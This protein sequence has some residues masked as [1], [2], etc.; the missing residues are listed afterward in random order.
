MT[1]EAELQAKIA[2]ISGKIN[3]AKQQQPHHPNTQYLAPHHYGPPRGRGYSRWAPYGRGGRGGR[4]G[5]GVPHPNRTLVLN[6]TST[7]PRPTS[8]HPDAMIVDS[9]PDH[10]P[11][12]PT[13]NY[14][15][16]QAL[17]RKQLMNKNT[18]E[19]EQK[20]ISELKEQA[21]AA[22]RQEVNRN[23]SSK[24]IQQASNQGSREILVEG[25]RFQLRDD[26]SK[27]IRVAG[28]FG[29]LCLINTP[30]DRLKHLDPTFASRET[31][32]KV[33]IADID[34][35][36]TK[37]G[38]L[39]RANAVKGLNRYSPAHQHIVRG[40]GSLHNSHR[41]V[42]QK[43]Q[44]QHFTKHGTL[45]P[46]LH[47]PSCLLLE[48][49]TKRGSV[50]GKCPFGLSCHYA[51][52]P[53][54]V[55][56]CPAFLK[57]TC[58]AGDD[59]DLSHEVSYSRVP[60]CAYFLRGNCTNDACR[61]PHVHVSPTASVCRPF[62]LLG[63]C[64]NADCEKRHV[65]EC[66]DYANH[67][68][69]SNRSCSLPHPDRASTLRKAAA[70]QA[71]IGSDNDSDLSS[72]EEDQQQDGAGFEDIDSDEAEDVMMGDANDGGHEL[73]Q[74]QDFISFS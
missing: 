35:F 70:K 43:P 71:K 38:N 56:I 67:G 1:E 10:Q 30:H 28:K 9:T 63:Y 15:S 24:L 31:P 6:G 8:V 13:T 54:E 51:H 41:T 7:P 48:M 59:C 29:R 32:K 12:T 53:E 40:Q 46:L 26:G 57:N 22:K 42:K 64:P 37:T 49:K 5:Y 19:R 18:Y 69:C 23:E 60:A 55:A 2:A 34:F 61:Y 47:W 36:R 44:C 33:T 66:P 16:A 20:Q 11:I 45:S 39:V 72:D 25:I 68:S 52:D 74:Q 4:G 58:T 3:Q 50:T 17:G 27:L 62:A 73:S 14:V 21:R 65:F